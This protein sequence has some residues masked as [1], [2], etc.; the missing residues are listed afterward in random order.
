MRLCRVALRF[1]N[2]L[3]SGT[4]G[5]KRDAG[6][7]CGA[8][9]MRLS[10]A[11]CMHRQ[12]GRSSTTRARH[13]QL[14]SENISTGTCTCTAVQGRGEAMSPRNSQDAKVN[15]VTDRGIKVVGLEA[16]TQL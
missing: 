8:G 9:L 13:L 5:L 11:D 10:C 7:S 4:N 12:C 15:N 1:E 2:V 16:R 14:D 3:T 6:C